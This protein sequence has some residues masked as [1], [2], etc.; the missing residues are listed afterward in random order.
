M[1]LGGGCRAQGQRSRIVYS[2]DTSDTLL[3]LMMLTW[4]PGPLWLRASREV[5]GPRYSGRSVGLLSMEA[6]SP[7]VSGRERRCG[8]QGSC[9]IY[10]NHSSQ[11]RRALPPAT[12]H[13]ASGHL[14]HSV[15]G[16]HRGQHQEEGPLRDALPAG[17]QGPQVAPFG[18]VSPT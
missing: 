15:G 9:D 18:L 2:W 16:P 6:G 7:K 13:S 5:S 8:G 11:R 14:W 17:H 1:G 10:C 3:L 4:G 12:A